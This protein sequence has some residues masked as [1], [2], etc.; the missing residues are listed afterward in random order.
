M[1]HSSLSPVERIEKAIYLIRGEKV[2]LDRD[3]AKLYGV[4]TKRL[5][6][7]VKRNRGR[8]PDDF[9][10]R[11]TSEEAKLAQ[12]SRS[13]FATLKRGRNIKYLPY[14]FTEHSVACI[15]HVARHLQKGV[16]LT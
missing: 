12:S 11:L 2:M 14:A 16:V 5:N 10:F 6:E 7:Q 9:M 3:L 8:F 4:T 13:Q 1:K 15:Q